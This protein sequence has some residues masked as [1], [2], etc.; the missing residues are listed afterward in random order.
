MWNQNL[1]VCAVKA[2]AQRT[3]AH[4]GRKHTTY[5]ESDIQGLISGLDSINSMLF[6]CPKTIGDTSVFETW[7]MLLT[8]FLKNQV[9]SFIR[10]PRIKMWAKMTEIQ[11]VENS[12]PKWKQH[13]SSKITKLDPTFPLKKHAPWY[14]KSSFVLV[15]NQRFVLLLRQPIAAAA[16]VVVVAV[17]GMSWQWDVMAVTSLWSFLKIAAFFKPNLAVAFNDAIVDYHGR[18]M[19][20]GWCCGAIQCGDTVVLKL[21]VLLFLQILYVS[22]DMNPTACISGSIDDLLSI[23]KLLLQ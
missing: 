20:G 7:E 9:D 10:P 4:N 1:G 17:I 2:G 21:L 15:W 16:I 19:A 3:P 13:S 8:W 5:R 14:C 11:K 6:Q 23:L 12:K 18:F 22:C